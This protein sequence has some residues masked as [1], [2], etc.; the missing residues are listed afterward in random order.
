[1][2]FA[3]FALAAPALLAPLNWLWKRLGLAI[4]K[5]MNPLILGIMFYGLMLPIGLL[6]RWRG[7]DLLRLKLD[8]AARSYWI[9]REP[10][11]P[12][13]ETMRNQY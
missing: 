12:P 5:V 13:P 3:A 4:S 8:P 11:G 10:P 7:K 1:M 6:L 2:L 9:D